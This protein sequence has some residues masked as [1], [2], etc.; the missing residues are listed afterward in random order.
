MCSKQ[1]EDT[2]AASNDAYVVTVGNFPDLPPNSEVRIDRTTDRAGYQVKECT[3]EV[4]SPEQ[5]LESW[6]SYSKSKSSC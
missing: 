3:S 1:K 6:R 2:L 5:A 4:S